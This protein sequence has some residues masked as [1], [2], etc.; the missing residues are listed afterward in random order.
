MNIRKWK[1]SNRILSERIE[2]DE[3]SQNHSKIENEISD[4]YSSE[5]F[6]PDENA[7]TKVLGVPWNTDTDGL[8]FSLDSLKKLTSGRITK[9]LLLRAVASV[10]DPLGILSP[11]VVTLKIL[12]QH[13]CKGLKDWDETLDLVNQERW[14]KFL[15]EVKDFTNLEIPR[16][17]QCV[18]GYSML[19]VGFSDASENAYAASYTLYVMMRKKKCFHH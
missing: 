18:K 7:P 12:F 17:F 1:T 14:D 6:N 4:L 16:S 8:H 13:V 2:A 9:R 11:I 15:H 19:L 10:F 5:P 3:I